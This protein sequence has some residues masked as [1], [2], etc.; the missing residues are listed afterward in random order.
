M[1]F[2]FPP[3]IKGLKACFSSKLY[4]CKLYGWLILNDDNGG[5]NS[6]I[7]LNMCDQGGGQ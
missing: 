1:T 4:D 5:V 6:S 2:L 7:T 3:D